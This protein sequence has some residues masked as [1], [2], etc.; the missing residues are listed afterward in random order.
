M[1]K[2]SRWFISRICIVI[3]IAMTLIFVSA[4]TASTA[5]VSRSTDNDDSFAHGANKQADSHPLIY[6]VGVRDAA[7][8]A[9]LTGTYD[10]IEAR[11]VDYLL[12]VGDDAVADALRQRGYT[13]AVD[14]ELSHN[15]PGAGASPQAYYNGYRT[16][17]EHYQH[18]DAI[19][20]AHPD[21]AVVHDYGDTWRKTQNQASGYDLRVICITKLRP[22]DC[23]LDPE[24]D[25][26]RFFLM[27]AIH[28]RELTTSE[29]AYRW[30][31]YLVESYNNDPDITALVDYNELWIVPVINPDGRA[32]VE[33]GGNS[34]VSQRKNVNPSNNPANQPFCAE[35][36]NGQ[37]GIDLN[38][39]ADFQW[40][41]A[42]TST[43]SCN[44]TYRG[45]AAASEPEEQ[46]LEALMRK[47]FRD[48]REDTLTAA[49]PMTTTG[50]M[51]SLHTF[52][53]LVL[54]PW[55]FPDCNADPCPADKKAPN[56]AGLRSLGFRMGFYNNY[57]VGQPS[58]VLYAAS[59]TSDDFAY[60]RL[61]I[62]GFTF[63]VGPGSGACAGFFPAYS[64]QDSK[65]WP[66]NR[67]AF[68]YAAKAARQPY[69]SALGPTTLTPTLSISHTTA[70]T[71]VTLTAIIDDNLYNNNP[72]SVGRPA[73]QIIT[74][75]EYYLDLPPW[76]EGTPIAMTTSDGAFDNSS[77]VVTARIE[78]AGLSAG[79][80]TIF[81]R[82][83]D[84]DGNV[85]PVT[86]Q[87]LFIDPAQQ[88]A[89]PTTV[90]PTTTPTATVAPTVVSDPYCGFIVPH[91]V[92][93]PFIQQQSNLHAPIDS[94]TS[95]AQPAPLQH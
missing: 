77:E 31:D 54:F 60:G 28:A 71:P 84:A 62:A 3:A 9:Y 10:V 79:R 42:S 45:P 12:I 88:T 69:V 92:Y 21:L 55:G 68:K 91:C 56:D 83:R 17:G 29:L 7:D 66:P 37:D 35:G 89:T 1:Y 25:K 81:V 93:M 50:V 43:N 82:G 26:P 64:C 47:L 46:A 87:W 33:S 15:L 16:V 44:L 36:F 57:Q 8:V 86:A 40:G 90:A 59:G 22:G 53:D 5:P 34:P 85:G 52:S 23:E 2:R 75:A 4:P 48:Q 51:L 41:G 30:L 65:F 49:A 18:M 58:E 13:V 27:A 63:E 39:N 19:V 32:V 11:G 67:D 94:F 80:H 95:S 78:T 73:T 70:G 6:R 72:G 74:A 24:T 76:A 20:V 38:R 61:G 14:H